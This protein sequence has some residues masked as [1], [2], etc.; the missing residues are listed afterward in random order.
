MYALRRVST[1]KNIQ[2][3]RHNVHGKRKRDRMNPLS[4]SAAEFSGGFYYLYLMIFT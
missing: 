2:P 1:S 3:Q 4:R